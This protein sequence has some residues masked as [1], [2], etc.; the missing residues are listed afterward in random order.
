M[1]AFPDS[2]RMINGCPGTGT[3]WG[4][5]RR[6]ADGTVE[7]TAE[8]MEHYH[9]QG[10]IILRQAF[11]KE[12]M[13]GLLSAV[14]RMVAKGVA[15]HETMD[16]AGGGDSQDSTVGPNLQWIDREKEFPTRTS[17]MLWPDKYE[18]EFGE[19]LEDVHPHLHAVIDHGGAGVRNSLFG[20]LS[21]GAG[22][23]YEQEWRES[24][25]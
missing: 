13:A 15:Q 11:T 17:N 1:E 2:G 19:W 4:H 8:D 12:R 10:F 7:I 9:R 14:R 22:V 6:R 24:A 21:S 5:G 23:P 16:A 25:F 20:M 18:P 3:T